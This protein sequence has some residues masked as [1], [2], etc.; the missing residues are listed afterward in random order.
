MEVVKV[1]LGDLQTNCYSIIND[2]N[3][4]VIVDPGAESEKV[5][6]LLKLRDLTLKGILITHGHFDHVGGVQG[7]QDYFDINTYAHVVE[8]KMM[9][10]GN[11]NLSSMF[12]RTVVECEANK[13]LK[14]DETINLGHDFEFKVIEVPGHTS[15]SLCFLHPDGHI[16]TGDT[17][18]NGS[19]GRTDLYDGDAKDL[20]V[21]IRKKIFSLDGHVK[22]YP[23]HGITT[24]IQHE[25]DTN[26]F[27]IL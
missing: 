5:I 12:A 1:M 17:L 25:V 24:T 4:C 8:S 23:G 3:Q 7:L 20:M 6:E 13:F 9:S 10:D 14:D 16:F 19:V 22:V 27:F 2:K 18:F 21:N 11:L 15:H 26:P